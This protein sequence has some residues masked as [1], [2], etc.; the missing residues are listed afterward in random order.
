[1]AA[2]LSSPARADELRRRGRAQAAAF[3]WDATA[4]RMESLYRKVMDAG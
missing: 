4:A 1:V 2:L 3:S